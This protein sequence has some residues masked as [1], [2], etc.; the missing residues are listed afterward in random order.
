MSKGQVL[1]HGKEERRSAFYLFIAGLIFLLIANN[2]DVEGVV[3]GLIMRLQVLGS[4]EALLL[5]LFYWKRC[6][7]CLLVR[8]YRSL[9]RKHYSCL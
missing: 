5:L 3:S 6:R 8:G 9:M 1:E 4:L 2:G 7:V